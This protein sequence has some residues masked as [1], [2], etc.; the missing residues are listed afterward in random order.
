MRKILFPTA[1][2]SL[3]L[4][5]MMLT[6]CLNDDDSTEKDYSEW[7]KE[8]VAFYNECAEQLDDNGQ[9][10]YD[11]LTLDIA[12]G[13]TILIHRYNQSPASAMRPMDNSLVNVKYEGKLCDGTVFD[14]SYS[15]KD[16]VYQCR[17]LDNIAGF[18]G[19]LTTMAEG[20]SVTVVIPAAAAYASSSSGDVKPYSTLVF[21][22]K[23]KK[24]VSWDSPMK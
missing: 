16:S 6:S 2:A 11:K 10:Y 7:R 9:P 24:I 8:N 18:W 13:L 17:P 23:L 20:D 22:L 1:I 4:S 21:D 15:K 14:S 3:L 5:P 12:S 19:A